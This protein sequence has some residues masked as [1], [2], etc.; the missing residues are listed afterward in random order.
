[1]LSGVLRLIANRLLLSSPSSKACQKSGPFPPPEL[2]GFIGRTSLSDSRS[3][4]HPS[5]GVWGGNPRAIGPPPMCRVALST[6]RDHYPGGS[7]RVHIRGF[8]PRSLQPSPLHRRV[9]IRIATSSNR[10]CGFP[11][12]GSPTGFISRPTT[13]VSPGVCVAELRQARQRWSHPRNIWSRAR[14]P[15]DARPLVDLG[16]DLFFDARISASGKTA[17]ASCHFPELGW[18]VTDARSVNDSGKLTSRKSQPIIG[19]GYAG[20]APVGWDGRSATLEAQAKAAISTGSRS[21]RETDTPARVGGMEEGMRSASD[22]VAKFNAARPGAPINIDT[23]VAAI[24]AFERALEPTLAPF[25]RWVAGDET[26]ISEAAKR[27]FAL[28][29]G[30]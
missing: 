28:F 1:M 27:G 30:K 11:A 10:T 22:Y 18:T 29:T 4:R 2:P 21:R 16:Y 23:I 13:V 7:E 3:R 25:D 17:C 8:L 12:Y 20:N 9:G 26:A 6:C 24:A 15:G 5:G 19:L 14:R